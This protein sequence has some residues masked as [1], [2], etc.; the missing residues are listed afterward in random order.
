[1]TYARVIPRDLF[2]EASLLKCLGCLWLALDEQLGHSAKLAHRPGAMFLVNQDPG[3]GAISCPTVSLT[4]DG[5]PVKLFRPLNSRADW[6]L[7][8]RF[9]DPEGVG[10]FEDVEV[11]DEA[12][13]LSDDFRQRIGLKP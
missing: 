7:W 12:G 4:V 9:G 1:M 8:A 13:Q 6:P 10:D 3:D 2:N 5:Q 11:F